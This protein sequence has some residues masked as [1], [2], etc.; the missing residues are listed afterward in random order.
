VASG[1]FVEALTERV[2]EIVVQS[3][4]ATAR[5]LVLVDASKYAR[6][7]ELYVPRCAWCKRIA[8]GGNWI[9][10]AQVPHFMDRVLADRVTDGICPSCFARQIGGATD[11]LSLHAGNKQSADRLVTELHDYELRQRADHVLAVSIPAKDARFVVQFLSR[12]ADCVEANRLDPV[13]V[14]IGRHSYV[15]AGR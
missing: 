10:S 3:E 13:Q 7:D 12:L 9:D 14:R 4:I 8:L 6:R 2:H 11:E 1:G 15:F 5:S